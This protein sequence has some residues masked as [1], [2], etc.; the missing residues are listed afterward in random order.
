MGDTNPE[1][2]WSW[3]RPDEGESEET[4]GRV[5][6]PSGSGGGSGSEAGGAPEEGDTK[7]AYLPPL[8][9]EPAPAPPWAPAKAAN[10][11]AGGSRWLAVAVVAALV[12]AG[13]GGGVATLV[14]DDDPATSASRSVSPFGNNTSNIA[15]PQDIQ[16]I[17]AKVQPGVVA[18]RTEAFGGGGGFDLLP[19]PQRGAG[20]GM[21]L[22]TAGDILTNAHVVTGAT[23]LKVTLFGEKEA[24][25]A[26]LRGLAP[27]AD[28]AVIRLRNLDGLD[29]RPVKLGSSQTLKVGDDVV[30]IGNALALPGGPTVTTGIVSAIERSIDA[31]NEQL[32]NLIQTDAAINP[33]N[34][35]GALVNAD[36]EVI[37]M[38]TAV[39][40]QDLAQNIG[41]AIAIDTIKPMLEP[42][43]K[44]EPLAAQ[45]FLGVST[46]TLTA[47]IRDQLDF[48]A[49]KGAVVAEVVAG[50]PAA[51]AGLQR[52]DV[53]T[54][55]GD[56]AIATNVDVQKEVRTK[57]PGD[58]VQIVWMRGDEER[59][60]EV[61]L[62]ARPGAQG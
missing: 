48:A 62:G 34:S 17:L 20:T 8:A 45:G 61:T 58:K 52:N 21:L 19:T 54:R 42:L 7:T 35:G 50:S 39:V 26:D 47:E 10:G 36:G 14:A 13:V 30:A 15:R 40:R 32:S 2:R 22:N 6:S 12:G 60:A 11:P 53:I 56:T 33:G 5:V 23:S 9:P 46:V 27:D 3:G 37:G 49:E 44:G 38:N 18:I 41:F 31:G 55:I 25:D 43:T 29:G 1:G 57:K 4:P 16:A 24:R 51:A 59:R 28:V